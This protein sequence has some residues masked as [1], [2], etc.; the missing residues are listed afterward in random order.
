MGSESGK[1]MWSS[2]EDQ[3]DATV[4]DDAMEQRA[5]G[6]EEQSSAR[7]PAHSNREPPFRHCLI[8]GL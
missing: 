6:D 1:V 5:L 8:S 3:G 7:R 4:E 2:A